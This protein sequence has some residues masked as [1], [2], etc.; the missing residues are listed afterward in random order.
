MNSLKQKL[1]MT[2]T[3]TLITQ[4]PDRVEKPCKN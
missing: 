2:V 1:K 3:L 4:S